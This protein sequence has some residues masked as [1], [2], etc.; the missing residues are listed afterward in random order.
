MFGVIR[1]VQA[2]LPALLR[3]REP[4]IVNVSSG[5]GSST[6]ATT[7]GSRYREVPLLSYNPSKAALNSVT[8]QFANELRGTRC[9]VNAVDPGYAATD[10]T[11][12]SRPTDRTAAKAAEVIV[13]FA[14]LP[15]DG[16]TGGF[17]DEHGE[18]PW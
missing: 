14:T 6:L 17:F 11:A 9:K 1:M 16:P 7:P 18:V 2:T 15:P 13:R 5:L 12:A 8:V 3:A 4:R 10:M